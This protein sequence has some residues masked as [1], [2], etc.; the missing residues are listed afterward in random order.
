MKNILLTLYLLAAVATGAFAQDTAPATFTNPLLPSGAD[1]W[2]IYHDGFYYY[3][4][5]AGKQLIIRKTKTM[6]GLGAAP[7]TIIWKA[8]DG[9][10][11]SK[12]LWAP[13]L[14][15]LRGK[16]YMYFAADDGSNDHHRIYALENLSPDPTLGEWTFKGQVGDASNKW[17]I[18]V[19]VFEHAGELYM[20]WSGWDG[21]GNGQQ[22]IYIAKMEN[23]YTIKGDRVKLSSPELDWEKFGTANPPHVGVNEGPEILEHGDKIFLIYSASGC[24]TDHYALGMLTAKASADLMDPKSWTKSPNP[25]LETSAENSVYAPG[26]NSFFK[27]PNGKEDWIIYHANPAPGCGCGGQRSPRMQKFIWKKDGSPDFG[28]PVK[29]GMPLAAPAG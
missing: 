15:Y 25:V 11:W 17:A 18:D 13:E 14:H 23:P 3:A 10:A 1:P 26:H 28:V 19:S 7:R 16:W 6:Q 9:T 5:S 8:P 4:N 12:E 29:T 20:L 21:D 27:S 22:N 24:W 2:V